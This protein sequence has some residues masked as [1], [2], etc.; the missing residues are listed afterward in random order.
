MRINDLPNI[1]IKCLLCTILIEVLI[2]IIIGVKNKK[3][4]LNIVLVNLLTNPVVVS[5]PIY[6]MV[7]KGMNARYY[8][9]A[10]LEVLTVFV[11]GFIYSKVFK[12][13][14]INPYLVSLILNIGSYLI[15]MV[16]NRFL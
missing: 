16:I 14:K 6:I 10:I 13:K 7:R 11:E 5:I 9:L 8:S 2:G 12:Y 3:D 15:G 1:M 4:I